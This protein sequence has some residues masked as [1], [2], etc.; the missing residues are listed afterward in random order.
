MGLIYKAGAGG[1]KPPAAGRLRPALDLAGLSRALGVL[2]ITA[3]L[4]LVL[5]GGGLL[6]YESWQQRQLTQQWHDIVSTLPAPLET[7][8]PDVAPQA[9]AAP[10]A[11]PTAAPVVTAGRSGGPAIAFGIRVPRLNY[12]SAVVEGVD[13]GHLALGPGHYPNTPLP[14]HPGNVGIAAHNSYWLGFGE[15]R[16]GDRIVLETRGGT[17][18]Y[19]VTGTRVV[20]PDDRTVFAQ[21]SGY[22]L[23]MTTCWPLWAG[24]LADRRYVISA[25]EE[26][27]VA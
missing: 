13:T 9:A 6:G 21:G 27:G 11:V 22:R 14:G 15:L 5:G 20:R 3:G 17:F 8:P 1:H 12:Y 19:R 25:E 18:T 26:G 4:L 10:V 24:A 23:T 2:L 16:A 7:A